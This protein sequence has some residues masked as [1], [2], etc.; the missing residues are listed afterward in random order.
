LFLIVHIC[1]GSGLLY[2]EIDFWGRNRMV[3][4]ADRS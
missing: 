4:M 1:F 3:V 2:I